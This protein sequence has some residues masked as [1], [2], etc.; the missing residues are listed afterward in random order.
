MIRWLIFLG[1]LAIPVAEI[2]LLVILTR[3]YGGWF[4]SYLLIT[5]LLGVR[6][7]SQEWQELRDVASGGERSPIMLFNVARGMIA[8]ILLLIPGVLTD[9]IAI[10]ILVMP[11]KISAKATDTSADKPSPNNVIEGEFRR[12]DDS[13]SK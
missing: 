13:A 1:L 2:L 3:D 5:A 4:L 11:D 7:I 10:A 6:L 8:G 9:I 12:E